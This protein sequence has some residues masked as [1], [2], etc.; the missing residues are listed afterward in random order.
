MATAR[1]DFHERHMTML[2]R[3][4]M[5]GT[6]AGAVY[7]DPVERGGVTVIPVARTIWTF[8]GGSGGVPNSEQGGAG[9]GGGGIT[10]PV[11]YIRIRDGKASFRPIIGLGPMLLAATAVGF[12]AARRWSR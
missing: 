5:R 1:T 4:V 3:A 2:S 7:G 8:G 11:G 10:M 12:A 6:G 9:G